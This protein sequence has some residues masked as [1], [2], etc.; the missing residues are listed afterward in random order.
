MLLDLNPIIL[1]DT[2]ETA[3]EQ[4]LY[5]LREYMEDPA[6]QINIDAGMRIVGDNKA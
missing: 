3:I 6:N 4:K 2:D 5:K 1:S